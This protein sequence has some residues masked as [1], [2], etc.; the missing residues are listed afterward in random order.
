[1]K[2]SK[3]DFQRNPN[4]GLF[5]FAT[6]SFC[7]LHRIVK[8]R[9][10]ELLEKTLKVR[11]VQSN[12]LGTS[13]AGIFLTGNSKGVVLSDRLYEDEISHIR[14]Q[15]D[16]LVLETRHTAL[17][18]LV[19]MNDKGIIISGEIKK[20]GKAIG[21]FFD[22]PVHVG[23]I[24]GEPL[25]GSLGIANNKG[26]LVHKN[27]RGSEKKAIE[28]TLGVP[29]MQG[30]VNFGNP[31]VKSGIIANSSGLL[32]GYLTSGPEM[33]IVAEALGFV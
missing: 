7:M 9:N 31:W 27:I 14:K 3:L 15:T 30:T 12:F 33:G 17:G 13:M 26:C 20:H 11:I 5:G 21:K 22:L 16:A 1:M 10:L 32:M 28:K 24:S 8:K 29:V 25:V 4:I 19:L 6:D 2:I 18:N 23:T